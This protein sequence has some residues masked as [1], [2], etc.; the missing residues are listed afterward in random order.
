M[1]YTH[2]QRSQSYMNGWLEVDDVVMLP[3][4][5][6]APAHEAWVSEAP[7]GPV[8]KQ[9]FVP[10][11]PPEPDPHERGCDWRTSR[12][13]PM[14][15]SHLSLLPQWHRKPPYRTLLS[16][17]AEMKMSDDPAIDDSLWK[18]CFALDVRLCVVRSHLH[19]CTNTC[20]KHSGG[21]QAGDPIRI[22]RFNFQHD[23][24]RLFYRRR[25]PKRKNN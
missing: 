23:Y 1:P 19:R 25:D 9:P 17:E 15:G 18:R 11:A 10:L 8:R 24:V 20:W 16:G 22:C 13:T 12:H 7:A 4:P 2:K 6:S 21:G 5:A 14:T 3:P